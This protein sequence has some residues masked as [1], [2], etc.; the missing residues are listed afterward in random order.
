MK[1]MRLLAAPLLLIPTFLLGQVKINEVLFSSSGNEVELKNFGSSS[2]DVSNWW[3]C[4]LFSYT[5]IGTLPI[6]SGELNIP[7]G[8]IFAVGGISIND[9][10]ADLGL[11]NV[12]NSFASISAMEDFVQWGGS[13]QGRESVAVSKGIWAAGDF[14]TTPAD[15]HSLEYDGDG[16]ASSDWFDQDN[17]TIG[18]ENGVLTSVESDLAGVPDGFNLA[19]NHPNPFNPSTQINYAIARSGRTQVEIFNILGS[20]VRTLVNAVQPAG[21]YSVRW[22]GK[23]DAGAVVANGVYVY[24]LRAGSFVDMKKM[25]FVK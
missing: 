13:G 10:S 23:N 21:T 11:Y 14:V 17:P 8:G 20:K 24:R 19:Q 16:N 3:L 18:S 4:T 7:A 15:G 2:M 9:A 6:I 25:L 12:S 1:L 22:D 5:R